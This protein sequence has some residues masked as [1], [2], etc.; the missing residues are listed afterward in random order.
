ML[1]FAKQR[2]QKESVER[3]DFS[4]AF[5]E[6]EENCR[7]IMLHP[8]YRPLLGDAVGLFLWASFVGRNWNCSTSLPI[9]EYESTKHFADDAGTLEL[10]ISLFSINTNRFV[11]PQM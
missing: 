4:F 7:L 2:L 5:I 1:I 11:A 3:F 10:G 8:Q 9:F 6:R